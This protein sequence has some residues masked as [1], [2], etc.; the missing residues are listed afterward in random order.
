MFVTLKGH[1]AALGAF[2]ERTDVEQDIQKSTATTT[3]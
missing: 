3:S 2:Y 1:R